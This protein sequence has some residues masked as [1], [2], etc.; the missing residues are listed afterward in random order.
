MV[1]ILHVHVVEMMRNVLAIMLYP[2]VVQ[3]E[4]RSDCDI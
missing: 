2:L 1:E 4:N 3:M